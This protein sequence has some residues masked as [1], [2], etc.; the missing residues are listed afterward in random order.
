MTISSKPDGE[1]TREADESLDKRMGQSLQAGDLPKDP[2]YLKLVESYQHAEFVQSKE[3]LDELQKRY[4]GDARLINFQKDLQMQLSLKDMSATHSLI[5]KRKKKRST[6]KLSFFTIF[7]VILVVIIFIGSYWVISEMTNTRKAADNS[8][9]LTWLKNQAEQLLSSGQPRVAAEIITQ[10]KSI[11]STY[12][13]IPDLLAQADELL[14]LETRYQ[15]ALSLMSE[16]KY[17]EAL[18]IFTEINQEKPD[19]WDIRQQIVTAETSIKISELME[20]GNKAYQEGNWKDVISAFEEALVLNPKLDDAQMKEQL[21]NG[22][23]RRIIQMLDSDSTT[24]EEIENAEQYYRKAV[25]MIPQSRA[26]ASERENLQKVSSSL[27][28]LKF[29]QTARSLLQEKNQTF[30]SISKAVSYLNKAVN[31][32]PQNQQLQTDKRNAESYQIAFQYYLDM[33]WGSAITNLNQLITIDQN[34]ANGNAAI[35]LYEAY[36]ALGSQYNSVGLY[37]DARNN[38]EQAEILAYD[39]KDNLLKLFQV[40]M[41]LGDTIGKSPDYKNGVSYYQFAL[42]SI[43]IYNRLEKFPDLADMVFNAETLA[44]AGSYKEAWDIYQKLQ[45]EISR[46]YTIKE[47]EVEDGTSLAFFADDNHSTSAA[48]ITANDLPQ[49]AIITFGRTIK[50]P[51]IEN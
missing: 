18:V 49:S 12:A 50:V 19:L 37:Q 5:E 45:Q 25:A 21:L 7:S 32:N 3:I 34:Y 6:L 16:S 20:L 42:T 24:I 4:P 28:E 11:D 31:L 8:V 47:I 30:A 44:T 15:N 14:A 17:A 1:N 43:N 26:F 48:I 2:D 22:Y 38:L 36:Y 35:L 41:L 29:T 33:N 9:L 46:I 10:M 23:L 27:L 40:Q 13:P 39:E 51:S